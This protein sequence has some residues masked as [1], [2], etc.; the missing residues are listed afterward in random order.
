MTVLTETTKKIRYL[1]SAVKELRQKVRDAEVPLFPSPHSVHDASRD[2]RDQLPADPQQRQL[3]RDV[4]TEPDSAGDP[5][6]RR[7]I[8][9][10]QRAVL[11]AHQQDRAAAARNDAL[12]VRPP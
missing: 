9:R 12:Q 11:L 3:P 7:P 10:R 4:P 8:H 2:E 1:E 6:H 5:G